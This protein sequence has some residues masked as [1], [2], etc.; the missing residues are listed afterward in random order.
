M[1]DDELLKL[2]RDI[3]SD[4]VERKESLSDPSK[5]YQAICAFANDLPNHQQPG[6]LFYGI[7]DDGTCTNTV[8]N[9]KLL[10]ELAQMRDNGQPGITD[11]RNP[12][13]AEAMKNVGFI[14]RFGV[15]IQVARRALEQNG[16]PPLEFNI[17]PTHVLATLRRRS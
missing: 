4:R 7:K 1:N 11:Y 8:I 12:S 9:D 10:L 16:N 15:G 13:I 14:Q 5:A 3:E 2:F 17:Q 6:V